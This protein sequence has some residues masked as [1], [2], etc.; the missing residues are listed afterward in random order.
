RQAAL[1]DTLR[2]AQSLGTEAAAWRQA[3]V[4]HEIAAADL[5][6][7]QR[8]E[9]QLRELRIR[10][11]AVATRIRFTLDAGADVLLDGLPLAGQGER[12][13]LKAGELSIA[14]V[15]RIGIEPGGGDLAALAGER[16][17]LEADQAALL[18]RLNLA[19]V[20]QAL[21]RQE[22]FRAAEHDLKRTQALLEQLAPR[23][24][25]ALSTELA[26]L[27]TRIDGLLVQQRTSAMEQG[28]DATPSTQADLLSMQAPVKPVLPV[29]E[30]E[31]SVQAAAAELRLAQASA[32]AAQTASLAARS[33]LAHAQAELQVSQQALQHPERQQRLDA[34]RHELQRT[35]EQREQLLAA[36]AQREADIRAAQPALIRQDVERLGRSAQQALALQTQRRDEL[37]T[38][39]AR[40][41]EA[42][43]Q[44]LD[45]TLADA[46]AQA[47]RLARRHAEL[48]LRAKA[49]DLLATLLEG[50]RHAL[51][52][53]LQAPLQK[54]LDRYLQLLFPQA[55]VVIDDTLSPGALTRMRDGL[56]SE[57]GDFQSLS[58]GS[59]EQMALISRLA[60]ADLLKE[61]G[62]PTLII[63]DDALVHSDMA[64][65]S[66][67][68]RILF[69]AATRHQVLLFTCHPDDWRDLGVAAR[70]IDSLKL[71]GT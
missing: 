42:G 60:Y 62:R 11:E 35:A 3:M 50:K 66:R 10:Q 13:L 41:E 53:R 40:L 29:P 34:G 58:F 7:L 64:R 63:L 48:S 4:T 68:K 69:D 9:A 27:S 32:Q 52:Q 24:L 1:A 61:A 67:M 15:G 26:D 44:G 39:Q 28:G 36:V 16:A 33:A 17:K 51:T 21:A 22:R 12:L 2:K 56:V 14:G 65:L 31:Q 25:E 55:S 49:L 38:L 19:D 20:A 23:G 54:H 30:A 45:D 46:L 47:E 59:R 37:I 57:T 5:Q 70:S 43:A 6:R 8:N 71:V 18:A